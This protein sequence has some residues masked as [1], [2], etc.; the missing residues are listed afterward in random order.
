MQNLFMAFIFVF[1][2]FTVTLGSIKIGLIPDFVGYLIMLKGLEELAHESTLFI[3]VKPFVIGMAG[4]SAV[5]YL[6][7]L[8]GATLS[9]GFLTYILAFI[10]M[11]ISL[12][13]SYHIVMGVLEIE[14]NHNTFLN[15][16]SLKSIWTLLAILNVL[17]FV[18]M[19]I[20]AIAL[21]LI[22]ISFIIAI[23]FLAAFGKTKNLYYEKVR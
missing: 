14:R 5:L 15:G 7:D 23:C 10:S 3:K 18:T 12:Y 6:I 21:I 17:T 20:S 1:L 22:I 11:A 19:F 13:I 16:D 4:Y 8:L 9:L 2:D